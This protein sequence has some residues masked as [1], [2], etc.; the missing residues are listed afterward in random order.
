MRLSQPTDKRPIVSAL[1][2][3][4]ARIVD[5]EGGPEGTQDV[6]IEDG[7]IREIGPD[8]VGGDG[9]EIDLERP[10]SC[11]GSSIFTSTSA[12]RG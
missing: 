1:L 5:P 10:S 12:N 11:P 6:R 9:P 3:R 8:L 7:L 2:L 4:R